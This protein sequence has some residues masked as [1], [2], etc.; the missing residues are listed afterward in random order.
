[1]SH[2]KTIAALLYLNIQNMVPRA[3]FEN[4]VFSSTPDCKCHYFLNT[5]A[6]VLHKINLE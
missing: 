4:R 2:A 6:I 3:T 1:M 5:N